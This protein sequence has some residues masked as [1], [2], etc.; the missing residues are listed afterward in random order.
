MSRR[1]LIA[2]TA[3]IAL[4]SVA[5]VAGAGTSKSGGL[6]PE[7]AGD[8][9]HSGVPDGFVPAALRAQQTL[10]RYFVVVDGPSV[11]GAVESNGRVAGRV[12]A[13][14][15]RSAR[16]SQRPAIAYAR[17]AGGDVVYRYDTLLNGFSAN[18][19]PDAAAA[20]AARS[21]VKSV[22]PVDVVQQLNETSVPFIGATDVWND[23]GVKGEG[24]VVADVDTGVDYTHANF[25]GPGTVEAY[26]ANDPNFIEPGTFPTDKV[27]GGYDLVGQDYDV[28]DD[29]PDNDVPRPD[30]DPLD[31]VD[32]DHGS[33]TSGTCCGD[34][35]PGEIGPGVAPESKL[36][37]IKVW[38]EGNS[39]DDVLV[40][41]Y[42][43]AMDPNND[44]NT[45]DAADVLTFSGGVDYGTLNS[46]EAQAAQRVVNM[47]TVFVAASGNSGNQPVGGEAYITGTPGTA[48]GVIS[49]AASIDEFN[50][51]TITIN[52]PAIDL[53]DDGIMV[54]QDWGADLPRRRDH[55]RP[56][57]RP[58]AR[59]AR[60]S[61]QRDPG[62]RAVLRPASGRLARRRG[63]ARLQGLDRRG[64]L[65][66]LAEG[67][68]RPAGRRDRGRADLAL[69]RRPLALASGG[70]NITIP[71]VM[72]TGN[73]GYAI[74]DELSP[75]NAYNTGTVNATLNADTTVI[76]AYTDAITDFSSEGPARLTNDLKPDISGARVRHPVDRRRH[77]RSGRGVLRNVD[78]DPARRGCRDAAAPAASELDAGAD[79]G[80]DHEP[81]CPG[82]EGQPARRA[83]LGDGDGLR[84]R[85]RARVGQGRLGR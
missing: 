16:Q 27:I 74:L 9:P 69:R 62:R 35:V 57:R 32:N 53:P 67:V 17:S 51:Q 46:V 43:R 8:R 60:E 39:T 31:E 54:Q 66:R 84:A 75:G 45:D 83:G 3:L 4:L 40:A 71:V 50:A 34:G 30:D 65:R 85:R 64:R 19:S 33:H 56:L 20:M 79:Q 41:G 59:P 18:L 28:L 68:Q 73:D 77:R 37:A 49:V 36:L 52:S 76:P 55:R 10:G 6:A 48:R 12:Q 44:G 81:G 5:A 58:R 80:G 82:A 38:D 42:E 13:Q 7:R 47:G 63:R 1:P 61:R 72:I 29:N 11:A 15:A 14:T 21:D 24:M 78:G 23:L 25:G 2:L 70:E 22:Q 26:E